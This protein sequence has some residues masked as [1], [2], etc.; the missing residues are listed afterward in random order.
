MILNRSNLADLFT[1]YNAAFKD[2]FGAYRSEAGMVSMTV[3][4]TAADEHYAWLGTWPGL[5]EWLGDR[6]IQQLK[7]H[8]Y[9]IKN[10]NY[11]STVEVDRN[12]IEDD[13]YGVYTPLMTEM[14]RSASAHKDELVFGLLLNGF[15]ALCYDGQNFFDEDHPVGRESVASVS[16]FGG[17]S[18]RAWFLLDTS[19]AIKPIIYQQRK[20]AEFIQI[21][22][23]E[24]E[25][26]F[27]TRKFLYGVDNRCNVGFGL[28][29]LAYAS[30]QPVTDANI[31]AA[32]AAMEAQKT[33]EGRPMGVRATHLFCDP[34]DREAALQYV[35]EYDGSGATNVN[36]NLI[37]VVSTPWLAQ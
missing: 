16:N 19:R 25:H 13:K 14:G 28:W 2:G 23:P 8:D 22:K 6:T 1:G 15:N 7:S 17:G 36:R 26:V 35:R 30:K 10:K 24:D 4:S 27:R 32:Y 31:S 5:R 9:R 34:R 20:A 11:E 21:N 37:T 29:Q 33:D 12:D 3:S 18:G